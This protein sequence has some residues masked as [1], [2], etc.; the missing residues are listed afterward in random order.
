MRRQTIAFGLCAAFLLTPCL[1][2]RADEGP[3]LPGLESL[4]EAPPPQA[5]SGSARHER[6]AR[7]RGLSTQREATV[8]PRASKREQQ[9]SASGVGARMQELRQART[10]QHSTAKALGDQPSRANALPDPAEAGTRGSEKNV[11]SL[12]SGKSPQRDAQGAKEDTLPSLSG[13]NPLPGKS[14]Q[15]APASGPQGQSRNQSS[16]LWRSQKAAR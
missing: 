2:V 8:E 9:S 15:P 6:A 3:I 14:R 12:R 13:R 1:D 7:K 10:P 4:P 16:R 11:R 5:D